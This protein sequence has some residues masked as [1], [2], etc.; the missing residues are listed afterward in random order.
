MRFLVLYQYPYLKTREQEKGE[1]FPTK[2]NCILIIKGVVSLFNS[3]PKQVY[4]N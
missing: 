3:I 1:L 4:N 2:S